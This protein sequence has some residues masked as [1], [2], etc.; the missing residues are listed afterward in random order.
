MGGDE[1]VVVLDNALDRQGIETIAHKLLSA[2]S[3]SVQLSGHE[4]NTTAS[5]GIAMFPIDGTDVHTLTKNADMAMYLAKEDGKNDFR[6]FTK[7]VRMQSI[8][9]LMLESRLRH[10]LE[11]DELFLHYQSKVDLATKADYRS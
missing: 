4:C 10:A 2:L 7:E 5:I 6:F 9:R 11:R 8:D 1:F 3:Q